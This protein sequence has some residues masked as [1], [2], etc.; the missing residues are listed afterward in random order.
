M[1]VTPT[2]MNLD[3]LPASLVLVAERAHQWRRICLA[4]TWVLQV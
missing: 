2:N 3:V 4:H 1:V